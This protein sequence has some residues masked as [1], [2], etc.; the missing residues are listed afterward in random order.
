MVLQILRHCPGLF[1]IFYH[2]SNAS[3][4]TWLGYDGA[5]TP[6]MDLMELMVEGE[7]YHQ[8]LPRL[9]INKI[10]NRVGIDNN[11]DPEAWTHPCQAQ[12]YEE[13]GQL[14]SII[15]ARRLKKSLLISTLAI[16]CR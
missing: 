7:H 16:I 11:F 15:H 10:G 4:G 3:T 8:S 5:T 14:I 12:A 9:A 1:G 6:E 13:I 2:H